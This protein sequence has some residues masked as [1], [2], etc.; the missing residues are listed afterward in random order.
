MAPNVVK[1]TP[2]DALSTLDVSSIVNAKYLPL[3]HPQEEQQRIEEQQEQQQQEEEDNYVEGAHLKDESHPANSY[4]DW[5]EETSEQNKEAV[6]ERIVAEDKIRDVL[7]VDHMIQNT[8]RANLKAD[9]EEQT[10]DVQE[11]TESYWEMP[12]PS[13]ENATSSDVV[14]AQHARDASHPKNS[15]WDWPV[16]TEEDQK[17]AFLEQIVKEEKIRQLLSAQ[18]MEDT[19][20]ANASN[21]DAEMIESNVNSD[22]YWT[23]KQQDECAQAPFHTYDD[24]HPHATY[25]EW[26]TLTEQEK[27]QKLIAQIIKGEHIRQ[28]LS[29]THLEDNLMR[30]SAHVDCIAG[31]QLQTAATAGGE[32]SYW[33][34]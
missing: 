27:K 14:E 11:S 26:E 31:N 10:E 18:H 24:S 16:M 19:M 33:E 30:D 21:E 7:S 20:V 4:W 32:Q 28:M 3:T 17:N 6:I 29:A 9:D 5:D 1:D 13:D 15:Y 34:W 23:D 12:A 2:I 22:S 8:I 25:W